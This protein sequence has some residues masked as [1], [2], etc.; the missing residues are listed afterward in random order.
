VASEDLRLAENAAGPT[1]MD[2]ARRFDPRHPGNAR[3]R[4]PRTCRRKRHEL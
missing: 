2:G 3:A 4:G 1:L